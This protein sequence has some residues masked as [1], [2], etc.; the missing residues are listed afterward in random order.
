[1][2]SVYCCSDSLFSTDSGIVILNYDAGKEPSEHNTN[3]SNDN[4]TKHT[5]V[6]GPVDVPLSCTAPPGHPQEGPLRQSAYLL[7]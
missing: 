1:M 2:F 7:F 4:I 6:T 5:N 3:D